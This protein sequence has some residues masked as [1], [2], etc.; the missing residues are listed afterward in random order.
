MSEIEGNT[1]ENTLSVTTEAQQ[2]PA[3]SPSSH[4][5]SA[6]LLEGFIITHINVTECLC[7]GVMFKTSNVTASVGLKQNSGLWSRLDF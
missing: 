6:E 5:S 3:A 2:A 1:R 4:G 7:Y